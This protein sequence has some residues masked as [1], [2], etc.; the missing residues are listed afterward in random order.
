MDRLNTFKLFIETNRNKIIATFIFL[1]ILCISTILFLN[2][3]K[4]VTTKTSSIVFSNSNLEKEKEEDSEYVYVDIKGEVETPGVYSL[5]NDKRVVDAINIAGGL[6]DDADTTLI[7]LSMKLKD[8]MVIVIYKKDDVI[9]YNAIKEVENNI[10]NEK[11]V[12]DSC[13]VNNSST[14]IIP[15]NEDKSKE[16]KNDDSSTKVN[17]NT[18]GKEELLSIPKIGEVKAK[19]IISYRESN[20]NFKSIDEIQ[21]V[22]G[23]GS[24]LFEAIKDYITI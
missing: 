22:K 11:I 3:D 17:I 12:N 15:N 2:I 21:N 8:Q 19:A 13:I 16:E 6:K 7:N 20:G 1:I 14:I 10:C 24:S 5:L 18:S 4:K 23:I 9:N